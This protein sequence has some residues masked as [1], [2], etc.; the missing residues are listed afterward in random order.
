MKNF[1]YGYELASWAN[2]KL[3]KD[4]IVLSTHRSISLFKT[5]T[6]S[7][8]FL[9]GVNLKEKESLIY[10]NFMKSK[11]INRIVFYDKK[12][13]FELF[14]RCLGKLLFYEKEVGRYVGR[15]PLNKGKKYDGWIYELK[16]K[17]M[18]D[19]FIK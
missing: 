15:N 18:P 5:K 13:N 16:Y 2:K 19:C 1:A 11:K 9:W 8:I 17:E 7:S 10:S 3:D 12:S 14:E 6:Y 4:D